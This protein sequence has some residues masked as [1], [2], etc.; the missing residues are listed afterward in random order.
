MKYW[1]QKPHQLI[2]EYV[3]TVLILEGFSA[4]ETAEQ[5]PLFTNGMP[6]LLC[7]TEKDPNGNENIIQLALFGKSTPADC[8]AVNDNT[9][10][11]AYFFKPFALASYI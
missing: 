3:R 11:I 5:L 9:T 6:A 10:I 1:Y 4:T 7:R 8:W 2:S